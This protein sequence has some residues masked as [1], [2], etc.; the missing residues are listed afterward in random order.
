MR[1]LAFY[2]EHASAGLLNRESCAQ[3]GA[4]AA[5]MRDIQVPAFLAAQQ[6]SHVNLWMNTGCGPGVP[7][8]T[9]EAAVCGAKRPAS[10]VG[11]ALR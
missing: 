11:Q 8:R 1:A 6:L 5:L 4:L 3:A 9:D 2:A 7:A 10:L